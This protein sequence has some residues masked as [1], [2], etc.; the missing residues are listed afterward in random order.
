MAA[1]CAELASLGAAV[2]SGVG[3]GA[4]EATWQAAQVAGNQ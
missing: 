1:A 2:F 4:G 3:M